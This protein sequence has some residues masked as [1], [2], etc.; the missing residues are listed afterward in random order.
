MMSDLIY[1]LVGLVLIAG[2]AVFVAAEFA[3]VALDPATLEAAE[4]A[5]GP[6]GGHPKR[7]AGVRRA[8]HRLSTQLS[9]AQVGITLTTVTLGFTTQPALARI[10][11]R[12]VDDDGPPAAGVATA[13]AG[14]LAFIVVNAVS[15][16]GGELAPKGYAIAKPEETAGHV[17]RFQ[18][19]F[20]ALVRPVTWVLG[21]SASGI[22]RL[23]GVRAVEELPGG[24]SAAEL[25][26]VVR[27]S[28]EAGTLDETLAAR[29]ARTLSLRDLRAI[30]VMT[31]RTRIVAAERNQTAAGVVRLARES[32]HSTFPVTDGS[33]D[34]VIGLVRLRRAV[35]VPYARRADVPVS[36]LMDEAM[37]VPET[38]AAILVLVDLRASGTPMAIVVDE[39]GG[40]SG[41]L[42]LEDL[43]EEIVG[44]V[45]DEHD[46]RR[47]RPRRGVDGSWRVPGETRPDELREM[48]GIRLPESAAYET[49]GGLVMA[50]L[51]RIPV[52][53]DDMVVDGVRLRVES[54]GG[55]RIEALRVWPA[56]E[57]GGGAA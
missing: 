54:M 20:T 42:T 48:A 10:L 27:R 17:A 3:F 21:V 44:D 11:A 35:A 1:V 46:P 26:S 49:L 53:G 33:I 13:A 38:A 56:S 55:R 9:G 39:Y 57:T 47:A 19:A 22:L 52:A 28:A 14:A 29:L 34:E 40:T 41:V 5:G 18:L 37:R 8:L 6:L 45:S 51:E 16:I 15:V 24:R 25:A 50:T 2:T 4:R 23:F 36:A 32:G 30:D 12:L 43:V 31:D 7:A